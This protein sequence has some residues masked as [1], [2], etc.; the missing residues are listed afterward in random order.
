MSY[1][2]GADTEFQTVTIADALEMLSANLSGQPE[3]RRVLIERASIGDLPSVASRAHGFFDGTVLDEAHWPIPA[4]TWLRFGEHTDDDWRRGDF[5]PLPTN[6]RYAELAEGHDVPLRLIGVRIGFDA[7]K[8][9][10]ESLPIEWVSA[11]GAIDLLL[12]LYGSGAGMV[13]AMALAKRAHSGLL[14]TR[15]RLFKWEALQLDDYLREKKVEKEASFR[16]LPAQFW[17]AEGNEA[18]TQNWVS[19]DFSTWIDHKFRWQAFGVEFG[20]RAVEA[21]LPPK[22]APLVEARPD[23]AG[24]EPVPVNEPVKPLMTTRGG[25]QPKAY[26][27]DAIGHVWSMIYNNELK[28]SRQAD[29]EAALSDRINNQSHPDDKP[30]STAATRQRAKAIWKRFSQD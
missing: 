4:E 15:A 8:S 18:L 2:R 23:V 22:T 1:D 17:W 11:C 26:W 7:L 6:D 20:R 28:P 29:I 12:P 10:V 27:E 24:L 25:S 16:T 13:A 30:P 3:S 5:T 9:L 21:M 14:K 19:G